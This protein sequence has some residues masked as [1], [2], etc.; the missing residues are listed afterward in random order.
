M[1]PQADPVAVDAALGRV[2]SAFW[3]SAGLLSAT[4]HR[5]YPDTGSSPAELLWQAALLQA[6]KD[7][8]STARSPHPGSGS[9]SGGEQQQARDWLLNDKGDFVR[10]CLMANMEPSRIRAWAFKQEARG[11]PPTNIVRYRPCGQPLAA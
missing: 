8:C 2:L 7:A 9:A 1:A 5:P 4:G 6:I 11:W 3:T 10:V